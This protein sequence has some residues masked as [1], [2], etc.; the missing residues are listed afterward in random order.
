MAHVEEA[1]RHCLE[2]GLTFV[3]FRW[4]HGLELWVQRQP[5]LLP[6][7]SDDADATSQIFAIAPFQGPER[8]IHGLRPDL[9][10]RLGVDEW[11]P[12]LLSGYTGS[13]TRSDIPATGWGAPGHAQAVRQAKALFASGELR[14]VVLARSV[15][16]PLP[17]GSL[18]ALFT[19][20]LDRYPKA[21]VCLLNCPEHGTWLGASPE[22]LIEASQ[23]KV[24][25][26]SIAGTK[27]WGDAPR[28]AAD[29]GA[30][31]RDE[32]ELVTDAVRQVFARYA[33][34][35][36][37][38]S[39][40]DVLRAGP[41]AHLHTRLIARL[42]STSL[43]RLV[44]SLH[45]TPAVCGTPT[46]KARAFILAHEP[47]ERGLYAGFWGP[48]QVDGTTAL[49]V[50]IRCLQAHT[51]T[52]SIRVGGGITAGSSADDEWQELAHKARTWTEAMAACAGRIP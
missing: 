19:D 46:D 50:N 8:L 43:A 4:Q 47:D 38:V 44:G 13:P 29:W 48:W 1:L 30:K 39:D 3:A 11:T 31:E 6:L 9:R 34:E 28:T 2:R 45:P 21:F 32:Q 15:Q 17:P 24:V 41:V 52:A 22:R 51:T 20:A 49:H 40:T 5:A 42:G 16:V 7:T 25:V 12:E 37:L 18:P 10:L 23:G 36:V 35:D 33:L 26:D 14:K 27:A